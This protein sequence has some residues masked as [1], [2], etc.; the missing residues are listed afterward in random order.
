MRAGFPGKHLLSGWNLT[1][2][3]ASALHYF[4]LLSALNT[5]KMS[6]FT[7]ALLSPWGDKH[8]GKAKSVLEKPALTLFQVN[9]HQHPGPSNYFL[10]VEST[11]SFPDLKLNAVLSEANMKIRIV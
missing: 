6:E 4:P 11:L 2:E 1:N 8:E 10:F 5:N 7:A 3:A 9:Q